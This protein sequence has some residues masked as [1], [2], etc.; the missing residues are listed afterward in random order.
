MEKIKLCKEVGFEEDCE[1]EFDFETEL[2]F[3]IENILVQV[4][5]GAVISNDD[6]LIKM[7][8]FYVKPGE[9]PETDDKIEC[10]AVAEFRISRSKFMNMFKNINKK[11]SYYQR[12]SDSL[13][14][15]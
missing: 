3:D 9:D 12:K 2:E 7:L 5:D 15:A 11:V 1:D 8:F 10:K 14:F 13:M 4:I 6:E